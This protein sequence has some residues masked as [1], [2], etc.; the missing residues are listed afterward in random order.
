M[1]IYFSQYI[2]IKR[3]RHQNYRN[4]HSEME[5]LNNT[6]TYTQNRIIKVK[7]SPL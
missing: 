5:Y 4:E 1:N 2:R 6:H 3:S 7:N